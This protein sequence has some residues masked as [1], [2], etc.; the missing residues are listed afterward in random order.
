MLKRIDSGA[1]GFAHPNA[2]IGNLTREGR[3]QARVYEACDHE[4]SHGGRNNF[5][6]RITEMVSRIVFNIVIGGKQ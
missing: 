5:A 1:E 3:D 2:I 6:R 4:E